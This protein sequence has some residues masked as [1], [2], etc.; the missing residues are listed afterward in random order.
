MTGFID[1]CALA[2][3]AAVLLATGGA[4]LA[5]LGGF[6][7]LLGHHGLVPG[8]LAAPLAV[9]VTLGEL[10]AGAAA[11]AALAG[12]DPRLGTTAFATAL[13]AG[14]AFIVYLRR[15][16]E[17]G[18]TGSCGCSPLAS[19]L[20]PASFVPAS[21]LAVAG[22]LGLVA[23]WAAGPA[24]PPGGAWSAL[25]VAWGV[26]LAALVLLLPASA[27]GRVAEVEP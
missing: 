27:P 19:P 1:L 7:R 24:P 12:G 8:A 22:V 14:A 13:G 10:A 16:L 23:R 15:L 4:H 9:G 6:S 20:T 17:A 26:T 21:A 3:V 25:P 11:L 2:L 5:G 18:H